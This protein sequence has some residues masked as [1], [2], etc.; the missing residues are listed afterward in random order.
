MDWFLYDSGLRHEE[1]NLPVT[2]KFE[3]S[4]VLCLV[5]LLVVKKFSTPDNNNNY[6]DNSKRKIKWTR[7]QVNINPNRNPINNRHP[8]KNYRE[9]TR[10]KTC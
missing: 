8:T 9:A 2:D 5:F 1:L 7:K 3:M 6:N 4:R 10:I